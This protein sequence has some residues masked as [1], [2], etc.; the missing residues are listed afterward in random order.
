VFKRGKRIQDSLT[1]TRTSFFGRIVG[2]FAGRTLDEEFWEELEELLIQA[3]MGVAT[4]LEVVEWIRAEAPRRRIRDADGVNALMKEHLL[5]I[6]QEKEQPYLP[7]ER[8]LSVV[9]VVGV[10][11]S[12]KTTSIAKLAAYHKERGD[13][14][15]LAAADTYRAAAIDQLRIWAERVS[16]DVIAH[17]P[18]ADPGAVV[19]DA[20]RAADSRH[21]DVLIADT[22]GRLHTQYN[23]MQ[24]LRKVHSVARKQV[25]RAPHETLLVLDATTGQNALSQARVFK[26]AVQITG[27]VLAKLDGTAK[28]GMAFAIAHELGVPIKFVGTGESLE[29]WAEFD[30]AA[31]VAG[32][33]GK[34]TGSNEQLS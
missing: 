22:A 16:V 32:L 25:H 34:S 15:L 14:V 23:L 27:G 24:E 11:G 1:R 29:D 4:T 17:Q 12:G 5:E 3:D 30:A 26:E 20:I 7:G 13:R 33:F 18:G 28:G 21:Y 8:R 2:L 10:N 19:Y 6:L 31:F 9:L